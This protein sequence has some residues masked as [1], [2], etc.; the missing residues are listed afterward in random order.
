M[1]DGDGR[2]FAF[3]TGASVGDVPVQICCQWRLR[4]VQGAQA[5]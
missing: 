4:A 3:C 1:L 2:R 5:P